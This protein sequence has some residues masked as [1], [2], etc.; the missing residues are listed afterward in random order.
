MRKLG[1]LGLGHMGMAIAKG[2]VTYVDPSEIAVY[3][4]HAEKLETAASLGIKT[5]S[6]PQQLCEE[7]ELIVIAVRPQNFE[8]TIQQL[9]EGKPRAV[10]SVIAGMPM[11]RFTDV[12]GN[13]PV[14]RAMPNTP[15]QEKEGAT[16]LCHN[17]YCSEELFQW[18]I[19]LFASMGC[20]YA[21]TEEQM[22][23]IIAVNGSSPAYFYYLIECMLKDAVNRGIDETVARELLV[24]TMIGSGTLLK[25]QPEKPVH[26]FVD[27]VCSKGGTTI[28]AITVMKENDLEAIIQKADEACIRRA[29]ELGKN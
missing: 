25:K 20:A 3:D 4:R 22:C 14:I 29:E 23:T 7:A 11:S 5:A 21:I 26:Q 8:E 6:S 24:Q 15:L 1:I 17:E 10:L 9:R 28:E 12:L 13:I 19:D 18:A 2:A 16:A 27:E